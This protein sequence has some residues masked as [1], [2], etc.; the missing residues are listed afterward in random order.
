MVKSLK[1]KSLYLDMENPDDRFLM[2]N[3]IP[4]FEQHK[5]D[6]IIIDEVHNIRQGDD[7]KD[8]KYYKDGKITPSVSI[9]LNQLINYNFNQS[10]KINYCFW[11]VCKYPFCRVM[12]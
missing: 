1:K 12:K 6:C 10:I 11:L 8:K 3:P 7:N 4:F 5:N 2:Q 9:V